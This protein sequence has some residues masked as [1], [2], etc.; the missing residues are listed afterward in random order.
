MEKRISLGQYGPQLWTRERAREI[1]RHAEAIFEE[2]RPGDTL[3]IDAKGVEVFDYSFA[4][5]LFGKTLLSLPHEYPDRFLVV[6]NLTR[7]TRENLER[8]LEG[9]GL[10]MIE[11][12]RAKLTLIGKVHPADQETFSAIVR[13]KRPVTAADLRKDLGINLNAVNERLA[14][15]SD[16]ALVRRRKSVSPAG[17]D[18][19]EYSVLT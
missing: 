15:L 4:N 10:I 17:R 3:V 13:V 5:E 12:N 9:M 7:Y 16:L 2:L 19:Y 14:K 1:R 8:A 18:Q 6:E 11:R